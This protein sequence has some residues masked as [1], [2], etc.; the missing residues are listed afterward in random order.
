[1]CSTR[2][3]EHMI[4]LFD[5]PRGIDHDKKQDIRANVI[6]PGY[7]QTP[8]LKEQIHQKSEPLQLTN[9]NILEIKTLTANAE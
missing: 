2:D 9:E 3:V 1:M 7:I 6:C 8:L 5:T 4:F